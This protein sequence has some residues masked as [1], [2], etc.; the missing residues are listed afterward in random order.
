MLLDESVDWSLELR[1]SR[2]ESLIRRRLAAAIEDLP[3]EQRIRLGTAVTN[4]P[5][6]APAPRP[7]CGR[8]R[9]LEE[10]RQR[11]M[12]AERWQHFKANYRDLGHSK[13][14]F[15]FFARWATDEYD[16]MPSDDWKVLKRMVDAHR[17][18]PASRSS[19]NAE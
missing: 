4:G 3:A 9:D 10:Q 7:K 13:A 11:E 16:D 12:V 6:E 5:E 8:R 1:L 18:T 17:K 2:L 15:E 14:S 19:K